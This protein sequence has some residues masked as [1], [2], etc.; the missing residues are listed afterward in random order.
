MASAIR[1]EIARMLIAEVADPRLQNCVV[2]EVA[3]TNDLSQARIFYGCHGDAVQ[4]KQGLKHAAPFLRRKLG[5]CLAMKAVPELKFE[6][7]TRPEELHHL[8]QVMG[9]LSS[10]PQADVVV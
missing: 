2:T 3:I 8:M 10:S 1:D 9:S 4:V 6:L 5:Q 7:D